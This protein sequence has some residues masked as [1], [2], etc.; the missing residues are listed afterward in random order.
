M[1]TSILILTN[2]FPFH[3]GEEYLEAELPYL[4][5]RFDRVTVVP[6][7]TTADMMLTRKVPEGVQVINP[8]A[9]RGMSGRV[10]DLASR[11][12]SDLRGRQAGSRAP[13]RLLRNPVHQVFDAYFE[14]RSMAALEKVLEYEDALASGDGGPVVIYSY[15]FYLTARIGATLKDRWGRSREVALVSR[16]HGYDVNVNASAVGYLPQRRF[17]LEHVDRLHPVSDFATRHFHMAYPEHRDKV[18]TR[19]LG[20]PRRLAGR[21]ADQAALRIVSV[22]TIR[23]LK[24]L[25]LIADAVELLRPRFPGVRWTHLGAGTGSYAEAFTASVQERLGPDVVEMPGHMANA[26]VHAWFRANPSTVFVNTSS[27]EGVPVS[28][29]EAMSHALPVVATDVGGTEE[30]FTTAMRPG[31]LP[32]DVDAAGVAEAIGRV[33]G[34][35]SEQYVGASEAA[36]TAWQST[37]DADRNFADFARELR[38]SVQC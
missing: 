10:R 23:P 30:L 9:G 7:M 33:L 22:S 5:E 36:F 17:L 29:M 8:L 6:V 27:S 26:D 32:A 1:T 12:A 34:L 18:A 20:S 37:W 24:R 2:Y 11:T 4:C 16:G 25:E 3:R 19:R 15:W 14:S 31:L 28:V 38:A 13:R 21:D 35:A